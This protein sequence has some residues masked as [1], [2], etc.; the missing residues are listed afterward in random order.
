MLTPITHIFTACMEEQEPKSSKRNS[1]QVNYSTKMRFVV[2]FFLYS[3][4]YNF[5]L[6]YIECVWNIFICKFKSYSASSWK[7]KILHSQNVSSYSNHSL[8]AFVPHSF[9]TQN[10]I[11]VSLYSCMVLSS[12]VQ[13]KTSS[14]KLSTVYVSQNSQQ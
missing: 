12:V 8:H 10:N 7:V 11:I 3:V 13:L 14:R 1:Q 6:P 2:L 4:Y 5:T 9:V